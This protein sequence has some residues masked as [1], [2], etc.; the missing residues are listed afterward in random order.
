MILSMLKISFKKQGWK[1]LLLVVIFVL[2]FVCIMST[3][4]FSSQANSMLDSSILANTYGNHIFI[5]PYDVD[6]RDFDENLTEVIG[7]ENIAKVTGL[8]S[9]RGTIGDDTNK[10]QVIG[11]D[12]DDLK[13]IG[14][15]VCG[16]EYNDIPNAVIV[17]KSSAKNLKLNVGDDFVFNVDGDAKDNFTV[18]NLCDDSA[19]FV[20]N[21]NAIL[22]DIDKI[23]EMS[24][25]ANKIQMML[26]RLENIENLD[27]EYM[28]ISSILDGEYL[29]ASKMTNVDQ[30]NFYVKPVDLVLTMFSAITAVLAVLLAYYTYKKILND[31]MPKYGA[32]M[33]LG[34]SKVKLIM[35]LVMEVVLLMA[36]VAVIGS[37]LGMVF[38]A[39]LL[40]QFVGMMSFVYNFA[41]VAIIFAVMTLVTLIIVGIAVFSNFR[42][43]TL[44]IIK[45]NEDVPSTSSK[46]QIIAKATTCSLGIV[47]FCIGIGL[48]FIASNTAQIIGFVSFLSGGAIISFFAVMLLIMALKKLSTLFAPKFYTATLRAGNTL[49]KSRGCVFIIF[50]LTMLISLTGLS[51][52]VITN[53]FSGFGNEMDMLMFSQG[54]QYD[55]SDIKNADANISDVYKAYSM[56]QDVKGVAL[57]IM[58]VDVDE[59]SHYTF[60]TYSRDFDGVMTDLQA[61]DK[62]ILVST[63]YLNQ[64]GISVGDNLA[65]QTVSGIEDFII[66]D[67]FETLENMGRTVIVHDLTFLQFF[68]SQTTLYHI[69]VSDIDK[70]DDTIVSITENELFEN[71][72]SLSK[73]SD[74]MQSNLMNV[75]MIITIVGM[76]LAVLCLVSIIC[77]VINI[78]LSVISESGVVATE[79]LLGKN[80]KAIAHEVGCVYVG[81]IGFI[82]SL[83]S[84]IF[85]GFA[86]NFIVNLLSSNIGAFTYSYSVSGLS[87]LY[88]MI[89]VIIAVAIPLAVMS[90]KNTIE[91]YK[92]RVL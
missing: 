26:V 1:Y 21:P 48:Q 57:T 8:F 52:T 19:F 55:V 9:G 28:R 44:N 6:H 62:G 87:I 66:V 83:L 27:E 20:Q 42:K 10:I 91:I 78:Y 45:G 39:V 54:N 60:D 35:F 92:E 24:G 33:S 5:K 41:H 63:T 86:N 89:T 88:V 12:F 75:N 72:V 46:S 51:K 14:A 34:V 23:Q 77:F 31:R 70:I 79:M 16:D 81:I 73:L 7:G 32:L 43:G 25:L 56:T 50:M 38:T 82:V 74:I 49:Q 15:N 40:G 80:R 69:N 65:L 53:S 3:L 90:R 85:T 30:Y 18:S 2:I 59:F 37:L 61:E 29:I 36:V 76:L 11:I 58:G 71:R 47:L 22:V 67:S 17:S 84:A 68:T 13:Y 4:S 64:H